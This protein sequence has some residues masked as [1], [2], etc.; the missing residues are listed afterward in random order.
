MS[1][2]GWVKD[3]IG[4]KPF[5]YHADD[6]FESQKLGVVAAAGSGTHVLKEFSDLISATEFSTRGQPNASE[7]AVSIALSLAG[8][9]L[10][11]EL[12][13]GESAPTLR[14]MFGGGYEIASFLNGRFQKL[15]DFTF[16]VW[17]ALVENNEVRISPT[18]PRFQ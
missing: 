14:C 12:H 11:A 17:E 5:W 18:P 10:R 13:G 2:V 3:E 15:G 1:F 4:L 7:T 8:C 9:L 16:I 6:V